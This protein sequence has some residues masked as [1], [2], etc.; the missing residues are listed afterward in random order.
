MDRK[1]ARDLLVEYAGG[2]C[3]ICGQPGGEMHEIVRRGVVGKGRKQS[4]LW[5][6]GNTLFLCHECHEQVQGQWWLCLEHVRRVRTQRELREFAHEYRA[7]FRTQ[8]GYVLAL[9]NGFECLK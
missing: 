7:E 8:H 6:P 4:V 3:E 9:E 5:M 1:N 2:L